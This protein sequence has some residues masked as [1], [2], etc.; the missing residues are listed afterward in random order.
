M[1]FG[2]EFII[3]IAADRN[4]N[5]VRNAGG[6]IFRYWTQ[7]FYLTSTNYKYNAV[8]ILHCPAE[9]GRG[10]LKLFNSIE[11]HNCVPNNRKVWKILHL[12]KPEIKVRIIELF[13]VE[14]RKKIKKL[15]KKR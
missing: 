14:F 6:Y 12:K 1:S 15:I 2:D 3:R 5:I 8:S 11:K 9:K 7:N 13:D 10:A 4:R